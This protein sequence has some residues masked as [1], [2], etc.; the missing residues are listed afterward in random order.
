MHY[1]D[2]MYI[3]GMIKI[4]EFSR[5]FSSIQFNLGRQLHHVGEAAEL[6]QIGL[7]QISSATTRRR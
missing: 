2:I 7:D 6:V 5:R 4:H 3:L 1:H